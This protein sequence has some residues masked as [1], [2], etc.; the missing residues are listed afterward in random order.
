MPQLQKVTG[1]ATSIR[2]E[3]GITTVRYH[4]TDVFRYDTRA[5]K[6]TLRSGGWES[7]TT[8][9]RINQCFNQYAPG[10]SLYQKNGTWYVWHRASDRLTKFRDGM[11]FQADA[12]DL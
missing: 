12:S 8:K 11:S 1:V 7:A 2:S 4:Q 10:F 9:V 3:Q 5:G 6:I